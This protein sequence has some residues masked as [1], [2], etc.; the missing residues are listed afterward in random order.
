MAARAVPKTALFK[1]RSTISVGVTGWTKLAAILNRTLIQKKRNIFLFFTKTVSFQE[2]RILYHTDAEKS[3][4]R[5]CRIILLFPVKNRKIPENNP[6]H[7]GK[8]MIR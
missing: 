1:F 6:L 7:L 5:N 8:L 3:L 4:P 2:V